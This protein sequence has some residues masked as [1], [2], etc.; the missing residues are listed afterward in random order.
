[1]KF[2]LLGNTGQIGW[3][4][5]RILPPLGQVIAMDFPEVDFNNPESLR[6]VVKRNRPDILINAAA[7]TAVDQ[8]ERDPEKAMA[9]NAVAPG[10]LAQEAAALG[11]GFVHYSTDYV[12]D[13]TKRSPYTEEDTPN[14]L[15]VYGRTKL[16]GDLA[17]E[18]AGGAW[19]ILRT[20]WVYGTRGSNFLLTMRRLARERTELRIVDDQVG[21]PTWCRS[22]AQATSDILVSILQSNESSPYEK[23]RKHNGIYNYS[24]QEEVSWYGFAKA[25]LESDPQRSS[26]RVREIHPISTSEYPAVA[27]RPP[28][29]VLSKEKIQRTFSIEISTWQDQLASCLSTNP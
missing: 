5:H 16:A 11:A 20:S 27:K 8:A 14:P 19:L 23:L 25:I 17:V 1:M 22:I 26:H 15:N 18:A 2:L 12:F 7:Y 29:S 4:L 24:A 3:E 28:Y 6:Q 9:I 13:G 21:N 10:I